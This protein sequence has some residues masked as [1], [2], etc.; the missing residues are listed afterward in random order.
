MVWTTQRRMGA[1]CAIIALIV[2]AATWS[3]VHLTQLRAILHQPYLGKNHPVVMAIAA[4]N[5][6]AIINSNDVFYRITLN[7]LSEEAL[8]EAVVAMRRLEDAFHAA[9]IAFDHASLATLTDYAADPVD[10]YLTPEVIA[11]VGVAA[12]AHS[13]YDK[14]FLENVFI[15]RLPDGRYTL[16]GAIMPTDTTVE[17]KRLYAIVHQLEYGQPFTWYD[18]YFGDMVRWLYA[19]ARVE[20][21][22]TRTTVLERTLRAIG[23]VPPAQKQSFGS[24]ITV[25]FFGWSLWRT[26][27]NVLSFSFIF[28]MVLCGSLLPFVIMR[29]C[30]GSWRQAIV[31]L[32]NNVVVLWIT[33][34]L[35]GIVD[36]ILRRFGAT[37][38]GQ[39]V[40]DLTGV[41]LPFSVHEETY[42][43]L[44]Y[45]PVMMFNYSFALRALKKWN[46]VLYERPWLSRAA[47]WERVRCDPTLSLSVRFVCTVA[48][49]DFV[50]FML[51]QHITASR[52]MA[53]VALLFITVTIA[54]IM[55][56]SVRMVAAWHMVIGGIG[57]K[58]RTMENAWWG[59]Q[60]VRYALWRGA[61]VVSGLGVIALVGVT[62]TLFA[63]G[64]LN[65]DSDP[66]AFLRRTDMGRTLV[67]LEQSGQ[68][69][70]AIYKD[71]IGL[72]GDDMHDPQTLREIVAH[73]A[74]LRRSG[75]VRGVMSPTD[76]LGEVFVKDFGHIC[77]SLEECLMPENQKRIA[78]EAEL[79]FRDVLAQE[80]A[81]I[82]EEP[83][84]P[85]YLSLK[86]N[87][88]IIGVTG[89]TSRTGDMRA[90]YDTIV[91]HGA[92]L[93]AAMVDPLALY[94]IVD[95]SIL[96]GYISNYVGSPLLIGCMV[97]GLLLWQAT[98]AKK[99]ARVHPGIAG[100]VVVVPFVVSTS[101]TLLVMMLCGI[102]MDISTAAIGNITVSAAADLPTFVVLKYEELRARYDDFAQCMRSSDMVDE[103]AQ[104]GAD[105]AV[106]G[107]TYAPLAMP[108]LV[109]FD[110]ILSLGVM[111]LVALGACYV[112]TVF[113]LTFLQYSNGGR[114]HLR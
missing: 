95:D 58:P 51:L 56:L 19:A 60:I 1:L 87:A 23:T 75:V 102:P 79:P 9:G 36:E 74:A 15:A 114:T 66:G 84:M 12:W 39:S 104:A 53:T 97:V 107:A 47:I 57:K 105:I 82:A 2:T 44:V 18:M 77:G 98:R 46:A 65:V 62:V 99:K 63:R 91:E 8:D 14:A 34:G 41:L 30:L 88:L 72:R 31:A 45:V 112:G 48:V 37:A 76:F 113:S 103:I 7:T 94:V 3:N 96:R 38:L 4:V 24:H 21:R 32:V 52:S 71:F 55:P 90:V 20:K 5:A 35:I 40:S 16:F 73:V 42:T 68:P 101:L 10:Y 80:W 28:S 106:N 100:A 86:D 49:A 27:I 69:G 109:V 92:T 29:M 50:F 13:A 111:L 93:R 17:E 61:P 70:G 85:H 78:A 6:R 11:E 26:L 108:F 110:P 54:V 59:R 81:L 25:E 64:Y 83:L 33:R 89:A 22:V 67:S 43:I